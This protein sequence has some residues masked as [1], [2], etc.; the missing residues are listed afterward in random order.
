MS[1][2]PETALAHPYTLSD[3]PEDKT[4]SLEKHMARLMEALECPTINESKIVKEHHLGIIRC[5]ACR[6]AIDPIDR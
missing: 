4:F 3:D 1:Y 5:R 2:Y 6:H